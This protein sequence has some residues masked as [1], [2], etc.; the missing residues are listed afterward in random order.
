MAVLD[1][2]KVYWTGD[3][4]TYVENDG[5]L[6]TLAEWIERISKFLPFDITVK[7]ETV[8]AKKIR[9]KKYFEKIYPIWVEERKCYFDR[10]LY[11]N[12]KERQAD[13]KKITKQL[14]KINKE[15]F[16]N[17]VYYWLFELQILLN[18]SDVKF[19]MNKVFEDL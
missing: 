13:I 8:E 6:W 7:E 5:V 15:D 14:S 17:K 18:E 2:Y 19:C 4:E 16:F 10:S 3:D 12:E 9:Y 11:R 1:K